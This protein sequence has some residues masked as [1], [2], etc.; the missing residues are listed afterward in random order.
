M[1]S[2]GAALV[3]AH[4]GITGQVELAGKTGVIDERYHTHFCIVVRG[5]ADSPL[6]FDVTIPA[7]EL[8]PVDMKFD[9]ILIGRLA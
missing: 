5:D 6:G 1:S 4:L 8:G 2:V 7:A 3:Q 9:I